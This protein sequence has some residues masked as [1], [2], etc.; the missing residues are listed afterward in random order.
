MSKHHG[1]A[2][3]LYTGEIS[4]DF[5]KNA[6]RWYIVS[7]VIVLICLPAWRCGD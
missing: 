1:L 2:H 5:I 6:K 4:Y 3:R 7:A